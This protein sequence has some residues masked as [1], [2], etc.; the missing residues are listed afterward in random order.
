MQKSSIPMVQLVLLLALLFLPI[1]VTPFLAV[2][3]YE[4]LLYLA[5]P[6]LSIIEALQVVLAI[7]YV[8]QSLVDEMEDSPTFV[9]VS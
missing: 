9:K 7:N 6:V 4:K 1:N 2:W 3:I 8:S 5:E